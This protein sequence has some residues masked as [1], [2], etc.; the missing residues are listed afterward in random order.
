MYNSDNLI[1]EALNL[2]IMKSFTVAYFT[3]MFDFRITS[4]LIR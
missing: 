4:A 1:R 2:A 3:V